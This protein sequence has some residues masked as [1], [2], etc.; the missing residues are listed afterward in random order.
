MYCCSSPLHNP[1][2]SANFRCALG[3]TTMEVALGIIVIRPCNALGVATTSLTACHRRSCFDEM[4][5]VIP[6]K[7]G[8]VHLR[9]VVGTTGDCWRWR[10]WWRWGWWRWGFPIPKD[11]S[12][13]ISAFVIVGKHNIRPGREVP[14]KH[15]R[16]G[17]ASVVNPGSVC[18]W[19]KRITEWPIISLIPTVG[20]EDRSLLHRQQEASQHEIVTLTQ[21]RSRILRIDV[22]FLVV[23]AAHVNICVVHKMV[24]DKLDQLTWV[25]VS[26]SCF[27]LPSSVEVRAL[28]F[29]CVPVS[30]PWPITEE[31]VDG[32]NHLHL[33]SIPRKPLLLC[34]IPTLMVTNLPLVGSSCQCSTLCEFVAE[35][36]VDNACAGQILHSVNIQLM[37]IRGIKSE[38]V[39]SLHTIVVPHNHRFLR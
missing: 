25:T 34:D 38:N 4:G 3:S 16:C 21:K 11:F 17:C 28:V 29:K 13:T 9:R 10:G 32:F 22:P 37:S 18:G 19:A 36:T 7:R 15:R 14:M 5:N 1:S 30:K 24:G 2:N 31:A 26:D 33:A 12:N 27:V 23:R 35:K 20:A 8:V 6:S 39:Y